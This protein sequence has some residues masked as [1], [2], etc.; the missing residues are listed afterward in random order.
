MKKRIFCFLSLLLISGA[1]HAEP[2]SG[3]SELE[4]FGNYTN[5]DGDNSLYASVAYGYYF[6]SQV[7][8]TLGLSAFGSDAGGSSD[9]TVGARTGVAYHFSPRGN[10]AYV[11]GNLYVLD[12]EEASDTVAVDAFLG[13]RSYLNETTALSYE[14]GYR[15]YFEDL[16]D[17]EVVANFGI[18]FLF[19]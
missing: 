9:I 19:D 10:T 13:Y 5:R 8:W 7:R 1:A 16:I 14:I 3:S 2:D 15:T 12:I 17:D 4:L 6:N 18:V 11:S